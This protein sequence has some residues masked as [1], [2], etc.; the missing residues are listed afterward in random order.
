MIFCQASKMQLKRRIELNLNEKKKEKKSNIQSFQQLII[1]SKRFM[2][3]MIK[4]VII[5]LE[6]FTKQVNLFIKFF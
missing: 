4:I 1:F 3:I 6:Q 5:Y 2:I